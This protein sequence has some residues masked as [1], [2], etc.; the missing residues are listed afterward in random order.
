MME[1][2]T[3]N[4]ELR[5]QLRDSQ[6]EQDSKAQAALKEKT[7]LCERLTSEV[8]EAKLTNGRLRMQ[9]EAKGRDHEDLQGQLKEIDEMKQ[10]LEKQKESY[11][12][13]EAEKESI[14]T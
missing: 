11:E 5:T 6:Q 1:L 9:L 13:L 10:E 8:K 2:N 12:D 4:E 14:Q 7:K 3:E